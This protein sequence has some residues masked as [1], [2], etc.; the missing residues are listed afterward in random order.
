[1]CVSPEQWK[2]GRDKGSLLD[3]GEEGRF[4]ADVCIS[5]RGWS[6][7][8]IRE[9]MFRAEGQ[10]LLYLL[11]HRTLYLNTAGKTKSRWFLWC[12]LKD[13]SLFIC[14]T[15]QPTMEAAINT[16]VTQFKTFAGKDGC[17][18]TLSRDEFQN[19]LTAQLP[20][21]VKVRLWNSSKPLLPV[22]KILWS[23]DPVFL[24][25]FFTDVKQWHK[26]GY[27]KNKIKPHSYQYYY[28]LVSHMVLDCKHV[29]GIKLRRSDSTVLT[30]SQHCQL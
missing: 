29:C 12:Y 8:I 7:Y 1:M 24:H 19:L 15:A 28:R 30:N 3:G 17:S 14:L 5:W 10:G 27:K 13:P 6:V 20:N 26:M 2:S 18:N 4:S 25:T 21:L 16:L 23:L 11:Q 9:V 22:I